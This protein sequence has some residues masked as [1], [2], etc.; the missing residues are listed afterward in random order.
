LLHNHSDWKS[1]LLAIIDN[2]TD[3]EFGLQ[4]R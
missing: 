3:G 1:G 4:G 2:I